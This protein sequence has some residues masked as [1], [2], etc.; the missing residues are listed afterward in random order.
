MKTIT[1]ILI[2]TVAFYAS[3]V[4]AADLQYTPYGTVES[5]GASPHGWQPQPQPSFQ[6]PR[7]DSDDYVAPNHR[8]DVDLQRGA[9]GYDGRRYIPAGRDP[10]PAPNVYRE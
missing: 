2:A 1:K 3:P 6:A 8:R 4:F 7:D 5:V 10:N 9:V